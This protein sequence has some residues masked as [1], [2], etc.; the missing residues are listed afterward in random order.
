MAPFLTSDFS[1]GLLLD[2]YHDSEEREILEVELQGQNWSSI[3]FAGEIL[4]H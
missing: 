1:D 2:F 4:N 3:P